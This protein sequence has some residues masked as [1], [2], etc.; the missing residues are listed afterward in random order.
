MLEYCDMESAFRAL[1]DTRVYKTPAAT[2]KQEQRRLRA[3]TFFTMVF[4]S[5]PSLSDEAH[6]FLVT[7][8]EYINKLLGPATNSDGKVSQF[9]N[10]ANRGQTLEYATHSTYNSFAGDS[11]EVIT[12]AFT[13]G[14]TWSFGVSNGTFH[15]KDG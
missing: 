14:T 2:W 11:R 12:I 3:G 7:N 8:R 4:T 9:I 1:S 10:F 15:I 13:N 6:Q 5:T